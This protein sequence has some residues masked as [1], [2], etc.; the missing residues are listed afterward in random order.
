MAKSDLYQLT[1]LL[2]RCREHDT[3]THFRRQR[4][5]VGSVETTGVLG[6]GLNT[7]SWILLKQKCKL[8]GRGKLPRTWKTFIVGS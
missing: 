5:G 8:A 7:K 1:S 6:I 2:N 4:Y 3:E